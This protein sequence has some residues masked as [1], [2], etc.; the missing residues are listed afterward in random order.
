MGNQWCNQ[1]LFNYTTM[2]TSNQHCAEKHMLVAADAMWEAAY[3]QSCFFVSDSAKEVLTS[4]GAC[5]NAADGFVYVFSAIAYGAS[6]QLVILLIA[7]LGQKMWDV[8]NYDRLEFEPDNK[9]L[10]FGNEDTDISLDTGIT[11]TE[12]RHFTDVS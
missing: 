7:Y 2:V 1:T 3:M 11:V 12:N 4:S 9:D 8:D 10:N 5:N 6:M